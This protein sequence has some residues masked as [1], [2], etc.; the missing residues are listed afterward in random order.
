[1]QLKLAKQPYLAKILHKSVLFKMILT[2]E[3]LN[4]KFV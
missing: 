3:N 4:K 1:M 2:K